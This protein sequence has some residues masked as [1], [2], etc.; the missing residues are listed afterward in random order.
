MDKVLMQ[1]DIEE[2]WEALNFEEIVEML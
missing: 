1:P 2:N